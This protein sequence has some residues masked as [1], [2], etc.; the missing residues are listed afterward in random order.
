MAFQANSNG[1]GRGLCQ[2]VDQEH[3]PPA[4][5]AIASPPSSRKRTASL[6]SLSQRDE[7]GART[8]TGVTPAFESKKAGA[9]TPESPTTELA[10]GAVTIVQGRAAAVAA[11]CS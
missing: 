11:N 3:S 10:M 8:S 9:D 4:Q 1:R 2:S 6:R 5:R 7:K